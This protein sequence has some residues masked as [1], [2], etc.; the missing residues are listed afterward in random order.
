MPS[1]SKQTDGLRRIR[2]RRYL[3]ARRSSILV[4]SLVTCVPAFADDLKAPA[5]TPR[6]LA[7]CMM[8]RLRADTSESYRS[9]FK[10]CREQFGSARAN[11][12]S[13]ALVSAA[14]LPENPQHPQHPQ[15]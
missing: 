15:Q 13:D 3:N 6:E 5:A 1:A 12:S 9:A 7:H 4:A 14:T 10:A 8:K 11:G 2:S